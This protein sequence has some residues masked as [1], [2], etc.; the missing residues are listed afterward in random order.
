MTDAQKK[1]VAYV[2]GSAGNCYQ[3]SDF[4]K[5]C[6]VGMLQTGE[7]VESDFDAVQ[8]GDRWLLEIKEYAASNDWKWEESNATHCS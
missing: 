5:R 4:T 6:I 3:M 7:V 8:D 2:H 1:L